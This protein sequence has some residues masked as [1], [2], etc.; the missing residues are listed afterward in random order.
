MKNKKKLKIRLFIGLVFLGIGLT[1]WLFLPSTVIKAKTDKEEQTSSTDKVANSTSEEET[2]KEEPTSSTSKEKTKKKKT[3][4]STT[5]KKT[6]KK[7]QTKKV[8]SVEGKPLVVKLYEKFPDLN[9]ESG[10]DK[11]FATKRIPTTENDV[12][13]EWVANEAGD[14]TEPANT[15][16]SSQS[17]LHISYIKM[18]DKTTPE[19]TKVMAV[20]VT[21][22][23]EDETVEI[24]GKAGL[25]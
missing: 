2:K 17:G 18:T 19:N 3:T 10:H 23:T 11:L 7:E 13:Y 6:E 24:G 21:V 12:T 15:F 25:S 22:T 4:N 1:S 8:A 9:A 14:P 16:D 5:E 20:P